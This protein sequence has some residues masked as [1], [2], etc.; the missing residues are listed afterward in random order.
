MTVS[1]EGCEWRTDVDTKVN[2]K[3]SKIQKGASLLL[4]QEKRYKL[5]PPLV[6]A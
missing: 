1:A 2:A 4:R 3:K 6:M 5:R